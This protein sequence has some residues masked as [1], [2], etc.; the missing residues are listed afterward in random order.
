MRPP[1]T[2]LAE[3]ADLYSSLTIA[4]NTYAALS[5]HVS[6]VAA[7]IAATA[8]PYTAIAAPAI[9]VK[10]SGIFLVSGWI[11]IS[12]NS[13]TLADADGVEFQPILG[14]A[15]IGPIAV[16]G[17]STT[18]GA[19]TGSTVSATYGFSFINNSAVVKGSPATFGV[20]VTSSN[21]H[22]SGVLVNYGQISVLEL[23]G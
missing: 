23:P 3:K 1:I 9:T 5:N 10:S 6:A 11:T 13:G 18:T 21:S 7:A 2:P 12:V 4:Q 22:T 15:A 14:G 8:A 19:P 16:V 20:Q 17:A